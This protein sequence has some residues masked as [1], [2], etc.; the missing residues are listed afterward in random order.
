MNFYLVSSLCSLFTFGVI[1]SF[2]NSF[3]GFYDEV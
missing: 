2:L 1:E 3:L